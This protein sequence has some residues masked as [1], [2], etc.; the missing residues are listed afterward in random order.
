MEYGRSYVRNVSVDGKLFDEGEDGGNLR[1][2][3]EKAASYF[4]GKALSTLLVDADRG[5]H[6]S[7]H[8]AVT[9]LALLRGCRISRAQG[10]EFRSK[11]RAS[12]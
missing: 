5:F 10:R 1:V 2:A 12:S 9:R 11:N 3:H 6:Y 8:A 7:R 4:Q